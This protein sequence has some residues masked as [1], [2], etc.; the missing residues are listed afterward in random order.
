MLDQILYAEF[1]IFS[2]KHIYIFFVSVR[3][4]TICGRQSVMTYLNR[5]SGRA[6]LIIQITVV[7]YVT[8]FNIS[9]DS[10]VVTSCTVRGSNSGMDKRSF[11]PKRPIRLWGPPSLLF[12]RYRGSF[13][14]LKRPGRGV[15]RSPPS[16]YKGKNEWSCTSTPPVCLHGVYRENCCT[17]V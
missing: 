2:S 16:N 1:G 10:V 8:Y 4:C 14:G 5:P 11:S 17:S 12:G 7:C 9:R 3:V 6:I 15:D 13:L